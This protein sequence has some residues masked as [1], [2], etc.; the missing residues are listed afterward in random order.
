MKTIKS[1]FAMLIVFATIPFVNAQSDKYERITGIKTQ[2]IKVNGVCNMC[3]MRIEKAALTVEGVKSANWNEDA[4]VLT[5][6]YDLFKKEAVNNVQKKIALAGHDTEMYKAEDNAY[7]K[8]HNCC[9][10]RG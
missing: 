6:K 8:L 2:T 10:Y 7:Q 1:L 4:K 9:H 3:K 5:V